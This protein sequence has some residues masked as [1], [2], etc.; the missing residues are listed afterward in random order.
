MIGK[1]IASQFIWVIIF[2]VIFIPL[3]LTYYQKNISGPIS[4]VSSGWKRSS[5]PFIFVH[6]TDTHINSLNEQYE[7]NLRKA[8]SS[9]SL[10]HPDAF[11]H[12]GDGVDDWTRIKRPRFGTQLPQE[13]QKYQELIQDFFPNFT[14]V[15][16]TTGN[17]DLFHLY[18]YDSDNLNYRKYF[19]YQNKFNS[20]EEFMVSKYETQDLT[21]IFLNGVNFPT[22]HTS[23]SFWINPSVQFL[24]RLEAVLDNCSTT[25]K[26]ILAGHHPIDSYLGDSKSSSSK[27]FKEIIDDDRIIGF[28]SGHHHPST[29]KYEHQNSYI[30]YIGCDV[31]QR[32]TYGLVTVDNDRIFYHNINPNNPPTALLTYPIPYDQTSSVSGFDEDQSTIRII[33][34]GDSPINISITGDITAD[35]E[36]VHSIKP[37]MFLYRYPLNELTEGK[38]YLKFTGDFEY[39]IEFQYKGM[40]TNIEVNIDNKRNLIDIMKLGLGILWAFLIYVTFPVDK[41]FNSFNIR[42]RVWVIAKE[43]LV[44]PKYWIIAISG[45]GLRSMF[46]GIP[47]IQ[48]II[49]F[50]IVMYHIFLPLFFTDCEGKVTM[51]WTFG[52]I[53]GGKIINDDYSPYYVLVFFIAVIIPM[54]IVMASI[55]VG[56]NRLV[57]LIEMGIAV[58]LGIA[59]MYIFYFL[60]ASEATG[61]GYQLSAVDYWFT[62]LIYVLVLYTLIKVEPGVAHSMTVTL[63]DQSFDFGV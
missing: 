11:L 30:D 49:I 22:C 24:D 3:T 21:F 5:I 58:A 28:F 23:L 27:T 59:L 56:M 36:D 51:Y 26:I 4:S 6:V 14:Y 41:I 34:F 47:I 57:S 40:I 45:L 44:L 48:R 1:L 60:P 42:Y 62:L 7:K 61:I 43:T 12:T 38:H 32:G 46:L 8:I 10:F 18:S 52:T 17:H 25:K 31:K 39:E 63:L 55:G 35:I 9:S 50:V 19:P 13:H 16:G 15:F 53:V 2:A 54:V 29:P 37:G 33:S 20:Y